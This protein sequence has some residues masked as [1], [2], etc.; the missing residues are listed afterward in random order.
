MGL[1][2]V[3]VFTHDSIALGEDG[4]THQPVEQLAGLRAV[5]KL[6]VIRPADANETA[7]AWRVAVETRDRPVALVLSRQTLPTLDR[8][9]LGA[10]EGLRRGAYVLA[11][12]AKGAPDL[13][14]IAS[15]SETSLIVAA[16]QALLEK[17][18]PGPRRL[19]AE[20][21]AV[22]PPA[23]RIPGQRFAAGGRRKAGRRGRSVAGL[24]SLRRRPRRC[25][26][27][28]SLWRLGARRG[29]D[30]RIRIQRRKRM[31]RALA[32]LG[33]H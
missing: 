6:I 15:G 19:D 32:L 24:A 2:V 33:R 17:K 1:H 28:G 26:R 31:R 10:A 21:G 29:G 9:A 11:D 27:H 13:L 8:E 20:L 16:R 4:S 30:A 18:N 3:Y 7:A 25:A 23:A 14:L 22:R 5:P 12:A